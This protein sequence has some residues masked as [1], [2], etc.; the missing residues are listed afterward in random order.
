MVFPPQDHVAV[1]TSNTVTTATR[2][3]SN[4]NNGSNSDFPARD[5]YHR[6]PASLFSFPDNG[7]PSIPLYPIVPSSQGREFVLDVD[8]EQERRRLPS[9]VANASMSS[10]TDLL[11]ILDD[12]LAIVDSADFDLNMMSHHHSNNK[13]NSKTT[14][15]DTYAGLRQ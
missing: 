15:K 14:K 7:I 2:S 5:F 8:D 3:T 9:N 12:V 6:L 10:T 13:N 1:C 4:H 11:S